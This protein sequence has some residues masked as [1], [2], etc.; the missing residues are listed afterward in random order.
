MYYLG[1][2]EACG[3][4]R[5]YVVELQVRVTGFHDIDTP[6]RLRSLVGT[7]AKRC[8]CSLKIRY[9]VRVPDFDLRVLALELQQKIFVP[10]QLFQEGCSERGC[11]MLR[12][13][14][15]FRVWRSTAHCL[16]FFGA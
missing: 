8:G 7:P 9:R 10:C 14:E 5:I 1:F 3:W 11:R 12:P 16:F 15:V 13:I 4:L 2:R 6:I